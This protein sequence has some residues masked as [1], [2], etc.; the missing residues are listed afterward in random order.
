MTFNEFCYECSSRTIHP[1][2]ALERPDV[3]AAIE[4]K[5]WDKVIW[6]L[7]NEF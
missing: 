2:F 6:L 7:D 4:A 5:D 1:S 3:M